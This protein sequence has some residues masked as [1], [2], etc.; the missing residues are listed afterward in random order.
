MKCLWKTFENYLTITIQMTM[1]MKDLVR[2]IALLKACWFQQNQKKQ[3]TGWN[4]ELI[5]FF[6]LYE[7][8]SI[9]SVL[10]TTTF[11]TKGTITWCTD[12][13]W[14]TTFKWKKICISTLK[15]VCLLSVI[16]DSKKQGYKNTTWVFSQILSPGKK[17]QVTMIL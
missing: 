11:K 17:V 2:E 15:Q 12:L 1:T 7:T 9:T 8:V 14:G 10:W 5:F 6:I 3:N 13:I 4:N 16:V